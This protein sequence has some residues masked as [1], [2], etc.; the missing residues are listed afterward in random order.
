MLTLLLYR[1]RNKQKFI[2]PLLILWILIPSQQHDR[3]LDN[4]TTREAIIRVTRK[5]ITTKGFQ[6]CELTVKGLGIPL[7]NDTGGFPSDFKF[8]KNK[9]PYQ[10]RANVAFSTEILH[11]K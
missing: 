6:R 9:Q 8:T 1:M 10:A 7:R 3:V 4:S 2:I 5:D 11:I